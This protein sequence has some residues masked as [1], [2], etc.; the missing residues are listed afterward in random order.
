MSIVMSNENFEKLVKK[1]LEE[2]PAKIKDKM[3]NVALVVENKPSSE[4]R[5]K[6][7]QRGLLFGLYQGVPQPKRGPGYAR[8][9]L[10]DKITIFKD[11]I[12]NRFE[13]QQA[14]KDKVKQVVWHE[15]A[16]HFGFDEAEVR[17]LEK[18]F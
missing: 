8:G 2:L 6:L 4:Q 15:V 10:P 3:E 17:E 5:R 14:I 1:G 13:Q 16:H 9:S 7:K 18:R 12:E 11:T